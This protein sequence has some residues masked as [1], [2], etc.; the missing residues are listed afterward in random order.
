MKRFFILAA[1]MM[2]GIMLSAQTQT[3]QGYVKTKGRLDDK[4]NLIPGHG[5]K[6]ATVSIKGRTTVLV[7]TD[8]GAFSFPVP[9]AQFRLD[10]VRKK[11]Y[12]L[13]DMDAC[14]RTYK[15]SSNP[16]YLVMETPEQQLQDE[17]VAERKI[18]RTLTDQ[19]PQGEVELEA[20]KEQ[21]KITDE[22]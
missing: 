3:Q 1:A 16:I 8:D 2:L 10:S 20:L 11:G 5:L 6:G 21:M 12:Q 7:N 13:V 22:E 14:P 17:L 15:H 4:G 18:R 9:E 19:L